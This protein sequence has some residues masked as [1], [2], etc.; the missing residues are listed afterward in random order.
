ME[1]LTGTLAVWEAINRRIWKAGQ[2]VA[3][4]N[5]NLLDFL[6]GYDRTVGIYATVGI[7][8]ETPGSQNV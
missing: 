2:A 3:A 5:A 7:A 6:N 1:I 8:P 4:L